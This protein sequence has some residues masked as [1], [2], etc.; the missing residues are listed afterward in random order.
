MAEGGMPG[1][2]VLE[3]RDGRIVAEAVRGV[4][5]AGSPH[6]VRPGDVWHHGSNGKPI[7]ATLVAKLVERGRLSWDTPLRVL[8]PDLAFS[9]R[10]EFLEVTLFQL[11]SHRSGLASESDS[12]FIEG[13]HEDARP[14]AQQRIAYLKRALSEAP[15]V[16]PGA[17]HYSNTAFVVAAAASERVTGRSFEDLVRAEIFRPLGMRSAGFGPT[18]RG[19]PLGHE[20]G[21]PLIGPRADNPLM[22]APAGAIHMSLRDYG[23]F[24]IDQMLGERGKGRLLSAATYR[25]LHQAV[26]DPSGQRSNGLDWG[27]RMEPFGRH[28]MH[29][30]SNGYWVAAVSLAPDVLNAAIIAANAEGEN[31]EKAVGRA[32]R[33]VR[34]GWPAPPPPA[35]AGAR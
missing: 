13:F 32:V 2:A 6:A 11:L 9:M 26:P 27:L 8:L 5:A 4:R 33:L 28:L 24:A 25:L 12:A 21:K 30:G 16:Q 7:T 3:I 23:L 1:V 10:P 14:L 35:V 17:Y 22:W 15:A 20:N 29:A 31:G 19:Q 18:R 34:S